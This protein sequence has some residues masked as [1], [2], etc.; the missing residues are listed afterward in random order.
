MEFDVNFMYYYCVLHPC[1]NLET[2]CCAVIVVSLLSY[3]LH[4]LLM[5]NICL[6]MFGMFRNREKFVKRS[7]VFGMLKNA[8]HIVPIL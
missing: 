1:I 4:A 8:I 7:V 6:S 5:L 2:R 3:D